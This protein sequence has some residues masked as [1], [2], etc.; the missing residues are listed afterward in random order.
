MAI[1]GKKLGP[2]EELMVAGGIL[3]AAMIAWYFMLYQP[4]ESK[5]RVLK[6]EIASEKDSI[7][8]VQKYITQDLAFKTRIEQIK[9]EIEDWE[10]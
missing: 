2:R 5:I 4:L 8:A 9:L 6:D 10:L 7:E 1:G 3:L